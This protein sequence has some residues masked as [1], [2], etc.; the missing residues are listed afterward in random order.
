MYCVSDDDNIY[1]YMISFIM[2]YLIYYCLSA[3]SPSLTSLTNRFH[4]IATCLYRVE[5]NEDKHLP[6][7]SHSNILELRS[8]SLELRNAAVDMLQTR[9]KRRLFLQGEE[10]LLAEDLLAAA[11]AQFELE[12]EEYCELMRKESYWGGGPEIVALCNYLQRPIHM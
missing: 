12:G 7:D 10:Y 8:K 9:R 1:M 2:F 6:M 5:S 3:N 11:S 4:S